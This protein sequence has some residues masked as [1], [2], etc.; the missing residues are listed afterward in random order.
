MNAVIYARFSSHHQQEQ[1]IDG[2]IRACE[3]Y[4]QK[5]DYKII[6]T[7]ADRAISGR[8]EDRPQFQQMIADARKKR[9]DFILVW[10]LDRF[11]R[12]R[13]DSALYKHELQKYG[14]RVLSVTEGIGEGD[15]SIIL[16]AL[17]EAMAEQYSLQLAKNVKRGMRESALQGKSVG[18]HALYG[19]KI[20][21]KHHVIDPPAAEVVKRVYED[22]AKGKTKAE[23]MR[24]L[25]NEGI[26][27]KGKPV[28][29]QAIDRMLRAERY[30]GVYTYEDISF[31][32]PQIITKELF[33]ACQKR[34]S[35]VPKHTRGK[36]DYFLAGKVFC[37]HCGK[38]MTGT[39]AKGRSGVYR[40]YKCSNCNRLESKAE[41][42]EYCTEQ[43]QNYVLLPESAE[44]IAHRVADTYNKD[45][46]P[47]RIKAIRTRLNAIER[48]QT[49]LMDKL[50]DD[51]E[52]VVKSA[53][54]RF[55]ELSEEAAS[56]EATLEEL[57]AVT[58]LKAESVREYL[59]Q[60][61][62]GDIKDEK[63]QK[64]MIDAFVNCLYVW[65]EYFIVYYNVKPNG[66]R[67]S[68]SQ[69]ADDLVCNK[70]KLVSQVRN[71]TNPWFFK[72]FIGVFN[73]R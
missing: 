43:A 5:H 58:P 48:K 30:T 7:Y 8:T 23:I 44:Y 66:D 32:I 39:S 4:A 53:K 38:A 25:N 10:K 31:D 68:Y 27:I 11:S 33:L 46:D 70:S 9:F 19:Y 72:A 17:L 61:C 21:N 41:L 2:Q 29:F 6:K 12:N 22:Y 69:A 60:Y 57:E 13:Y 28:S 63:F 14:V 26:K 55:D 18:G 45:I 47:D 71:K 65:K 51:N 35:L 1:S 67:V 16:E 15:E 37:G 42:E 62:E 54:K 52:N 20:E 36:A 59:N 73:A 49:A 40:Y 50:I 24:E 56:L 3:E 34:Q 64:K